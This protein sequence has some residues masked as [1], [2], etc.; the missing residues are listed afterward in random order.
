MKRFRSFS[1]LAII[2]LLLAFTAACGNTSSNSADKNS[3]S[4]SSSK[5]TETTKKLS[6][7]IVIAGSS[8]LQP[9]VAAAAD[10]FS[11]K[12]PNLQIQVNGGGSGTGLSE[13]AAKKIDIG[14]SDIFASEK[15]GL[16]T[17]GLVDHQ[18]AVVGMTAAI[19]PKAGVKN[20]TTQQLIDVFMG[21]V[22]NWKE[23]GGNDV[24][25]TVINRPQG[26]GTRATFV[27]YAL[28]GNNPTDKGI[29]QDSSNTV[30]QMVEQTDGAIGYE[31]LSYF[32]GDSKDKMVALSIDGVKPT[33]ENIQTG[34]FP[35][36]AYEHMYTHGQPN[37]VEKAFLD[38]MVSDA[39]QTKLVPAQGY[40]SS[41]KMQVQRDS[42]GK[43]TKK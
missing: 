15:K 25:V 4:K 31:A 19:N 23:V 7:K 13:I 9:L 40:I 24:P 36:W 16:D 34:Q 14:D 22:K 27:K 37:A 5:S 43:V 12:N 41:T 33:I 3:G 35:V 17:T 21:K 38:Y 26:S 42:S 6:G 10:Q 29:A 39:V 20:L 11:Q 8:A 18:V 1:L 32:T 30:A 2:M 28:K